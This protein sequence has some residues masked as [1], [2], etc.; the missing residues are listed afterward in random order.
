MVC[1]CGLG[2]K[3]W[4]I[5]NWASYGQA[6]VVLGGHPHLI[7]ISNVSFSFFNSSFEGT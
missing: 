7:S 2:G 3:I 5:V 1:V 6:A 4:V